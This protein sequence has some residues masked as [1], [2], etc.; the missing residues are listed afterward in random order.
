MPSVSMEDGYNQD[1]V[2][3]FDK[4]F[5]DVLLGAAK[6]LCRP[7]SWDDDAGD[8]TVTARD[9]FELLT[10]LMT[11]VELAV[12]DPNW[13]LQWEG[14]LG[15]SNTNDRWSIP[16]PQ[17]GGTRE[18]AGEFINTIT[19]NP[20][21]DVFGL[22]VEG[23]DF[24]GG[25]MYAMTIQSAGEVE[26][27]ITVQSVPCVGNTLIHSGFTPYNIPAGIWQNHH[28]VSGSGPLIVQVAI[29]GDY[30]CVNA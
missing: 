16:E 6:V 7:E 19:G 15:T 2:V 22:T 13:F 29:L 8:E 24:C 10:R 3:A 30:V 21:F 11:P 5:L 17:T 20:E 18:Y 12:P 4:R 25:N 9:G 26:V 28:I 27:A 23:E 1:W 14:S